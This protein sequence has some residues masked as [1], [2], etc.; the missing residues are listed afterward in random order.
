MSKRI[1]DDIEG[2]LVGAAA[3]AA[4]FYG[5][6]GLAKLVTAP[7][8]SSHHELNNSHARLSQHT[9]VTHHR[10]VREVYIRKEPTTIDMGEVEQYDPYDIN[11][12]VQAQKQFNNNQARIQE[13]QNINNFY[14]QLHEKQ[15]AAEGGY[16]WQ[17]QARAEAKTARKAQVRKEK[18][19]IASWFTK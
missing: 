14:H 2:A 13:R 4:V 15:V 9:V 19:I 16:P 10:E 6:R 7:F 18:G 11:N 1:K 17:Q 3:G 5:I 12:L 8:R